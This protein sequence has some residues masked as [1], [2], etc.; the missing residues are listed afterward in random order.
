MMIGTQVIALLFPALS[1]GNEMAEGETGFALDL[2]DAPD[3][4]PPD[5]DG[6]EV[7]ED[8]PPTAEPPCWWP[9]MPT[10]KGAIPPPTGDGQASDPISDMT[11]QTAADP[12]AQPKPDIPAETAS[13]DEAIPETAPDAAPERKAEPP[14]EGARDE[15]PP[16]QRTEPRIEPRTEPRPEPRIEQRPAPDPQVRR[17][18]APEPQMPTPIQAEP[19]E[20]PGDLGEIQVMFEKE[21]ETTRII[22]IADKPETVDLMRRNAEQLQNELRQEGLEGADLSF[23]ERQERQPQGQKQG[24]EDTPVMAPV[25]PAHSGS[26]LDLRL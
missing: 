24:S 3:L 14:P 22:L 5:L 9:E 6:E 13:P 8:A 11:Q 10:E 25:L 21:G 23:A 7:E 2:G 1:L 12:L 20:N 17:M 15:A 19:A 16:E 26:G 4:P 18:T